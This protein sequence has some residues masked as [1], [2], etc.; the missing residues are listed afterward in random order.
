MRIYRYKVFRCQNCDSKFM[1]NRNEYRV[2]SD[3]YNGSLY[4]TICPYCNRTVQ[5]H[6]NDFIKGVMFE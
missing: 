5:S 6:T 4:E 3:P 1:A 2:L